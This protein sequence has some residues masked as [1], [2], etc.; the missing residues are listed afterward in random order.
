MLA[1][2]PDQPPANRDSTVASLE[3]ATAALLTAKELSQQHP[4]RATARNPAQGAHGIG[5]AHF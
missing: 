2:I 1:N 5:V 3:N 4:T